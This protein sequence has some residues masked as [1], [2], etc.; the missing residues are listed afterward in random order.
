[1][2]IIKAILEAGIMFWEIGEIDRALEVLKTLY[3]L[4][5][6]DPI[7]VRYYILA[8]LE[9]M[10]F[11]EFELTFGKN[12]GYDKESLEKWFKNHGEKLKEL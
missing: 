9:G 8:I 12:G 3:R 1:R 5:P 11:E 4:D 10:G 2:H 7:G 6:D